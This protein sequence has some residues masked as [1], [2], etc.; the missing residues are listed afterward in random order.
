M[1]KYFIHNGKEQDGPFSV[2]D[3]KQKGITHKTMI[4]FEGIQAWTEAQYI[5]ELKEFATSGPPPFTKSNPIKDTFDK[6]K[7]VL[8]KDIVNEIENKISDKIGKKFFK[9]SI[10]ILAVIGLIVVGSYLIKQT[11][12]VNKSDG[13]PT[14]SLVVVRPTGSAYFSRYDNKWQLSIKGEMFNKSSVTSYKDFVVEVQYLSS[15]KTL[16]AT[17]QFTIYKSIEPLD[18]DY[19]YATLDGDAPDG[20]SILKWKLIGA[21]P[22]TAD[23]GQK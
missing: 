9:W 14:D 16:L 3:L 2:D 19:F 11:P 23:S 17:R 7:K 12:L 13:N 8:E 22:A 15:T 4:W 21:T 1:K 6:T 20:S 10:I 5:P 18:K